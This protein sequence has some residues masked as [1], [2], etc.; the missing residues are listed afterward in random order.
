MFFLN[1]K[2]TTSPVDPGVTNRPIRLKLTARTDDPKILRTILKIHWS[3]QT[4]SF[5]RSANAADIAYGTLWSRG[6]K[7][8]FSG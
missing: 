4:K 6:Y 8:E 5:W 2:E 3:S 7:F 1:T